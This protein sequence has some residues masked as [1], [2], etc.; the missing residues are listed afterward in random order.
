MIH[1]N[2]VY[3]IATFVL[4]NI[5]VNVINQLLKINHCCI[6]IIRSKTITITNLN[7]PFCFN[8]FDW[9]N[10]IR[11]KEKKWFIFLIYDKERK[12]E[13]LISFLFLFVEMNKNFIFVLFSKTAYPQIRVM[14]NNVVLR[15]TS[16]SYAD[17]HK[18][19][20][21]SNYLEE[22][23]KHKCPLNMKLLVFFLEM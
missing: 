13:N 2:F 5:L 15:F 14:R 16:L 11:E 7:I 4:K 12:K 8:I 6:V 22:S 10:E 19:I 18:Y 1:Q 23:Q 17:A 9:E 3:G 20:F 21:N